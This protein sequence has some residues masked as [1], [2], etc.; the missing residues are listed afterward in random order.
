MI[1]DVC[2]N[3]EWREGYLPD[4]RHLPLG[5][6]PQHMHHLPKDQPLAVICRSGYHA[7]VGASILAARG[8][9]V[10]AVRG[11]VPDWFEHDYPV[12][13]KIALFSDHAADHVH[14]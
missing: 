6:L 14:Y 12:D 4:S 10:I 2:R 3:G 8:Y 9:G 5:D 13:N 1:V 7:E 11:G